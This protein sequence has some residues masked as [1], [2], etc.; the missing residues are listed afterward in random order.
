MSHPKL[1]PVVVS[2]AA[3]RPAEPQV[4]GIL[5]R[6][7]ERLLPAVVEKARELAVRDFVRAR[8]PS[9]DVE[10]HTARLRRQPGVRYDCENVG[11]DA[12]GASV[13]IVHK[14]TALRPTLQGVSVNIIFDPG[15]H[16]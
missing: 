16:L 15:F 7:P 3:R 1:V 8:S 14:Y 11:I 4:G 6:R 12:H 9:R 13:L 5:D 10:H 2:S